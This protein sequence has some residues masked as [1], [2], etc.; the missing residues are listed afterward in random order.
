MEWILTPGSSNIEK[1]RHDQE[2][3]ILEIEFK[4]GTIYQYFDVPLSVFEAFTSEVNSGG[5]AGQF[6]NSNIK[7][8]YRY[9][10]I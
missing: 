6:F 3:Q 10:R 9:S 2:S 1:F 8:Y 7:G 5:S 4:K